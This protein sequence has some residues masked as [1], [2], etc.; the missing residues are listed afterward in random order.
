[1]GFYECC[2]SAVSPWFIPMPIT[3]LVYNQACHTIVLLIGSCLFYPSFLILDNIFIQASINNTNFNKKNTVNKCFSSASW[4]RVS[5]SC[6]VVT[7]FKDKKPSSYCTNLPNEHYRLLGAGPVNSR[8]DRFLRN[9]AKHMCKTLLIMLTCCE[10]ARGFL[11]MSVN[12]LSV[13]N[14]YMN[15]LSH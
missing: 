13:W 5:A 3:E 1:M 15:C 12:V 10:Q 7:R 4:N 11:S 2:M 8:E 9:M 14:K 6:S